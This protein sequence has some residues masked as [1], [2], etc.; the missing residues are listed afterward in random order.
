MK[1]KVLSFATNTESFFETY[2]LAELSVQKPVADVIFESMQPIHITSILADEY[3]SEVDYAS[4]LI[5]LM[6]IRYALCNVAKTFTTANDIIFNL[7]EIENRLFNLQRNDAK[8]LFFPNVDWFAETYK[9]NS[10]SWWDSV[11]CCAMFH[12]CRLLLYR[13]MIHRICDVQI[14]SSSS[15]TYTVDPKISP[16]LFSESKFEYYFDLFGESAIFLSE[17]Y[18][19]MNRLQLLH[20]MIDFCMISFQCTGALL[21]MA[22]VIQSKREYK[23]RYNDMLSHIEENMKFINCYRRLYAHIPPILNALVKLKERVL[24]VDTSKGLRIAFEY[25]RETLDIEIISIMG[26]DINV[27][28]DSSTLEENSHLTYP[29]A[30]N[31][32]TLTD[33]QILDDIFN[34]FSI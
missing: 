29:K 2:N 16:S 19:T 13:L 17:L 7:I 33:I 6:H 31:S 12:V 1:K 8:I 27:N 34:K 25:V 30:V 4:T 21:I 11:Y 26:K 24:S 9:H 32:A 3:Q 10:A 5:D 20:I 28:L 22:L 23:C 15:Y 18:G 14:T